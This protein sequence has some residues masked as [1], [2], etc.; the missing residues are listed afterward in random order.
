MDC[1][2]W[3]PVKGYELLYE[4]SNM[5][6]VKILQKMV[7]YGRIQEEMIAKLRLDKD[8]YVTFTASKN[9]VVKTLKVHRMV[10]IAFIPNPDSKPEVN[11][12]FGIKIDNRATE[13]EWSTTKENIVHN[14]KVLNRKRPNWM[15][16]VV[17]KLN[18]QSRPVIQMDMSG[19]NIK[20]WESM[21]MVYPVLGIHAGS[22]SACCRGLCH[23]SGGFKWKYK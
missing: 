19:K 3:E 22:I 9:N 15:R 1:E 16:G 11:H 13:L 6:R 4:I 21:N 2:L 7:A 5:G 18:K 17:G 10:A 12:R 14:F 23:Q 20:E 8:G